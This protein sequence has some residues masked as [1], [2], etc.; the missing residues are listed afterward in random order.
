[1]TKLI[2][3]LFKPILLA[4]F[5]LPRSLQRFSASLLGFLWFDLLRVR[6]KIVLDNLRLAFPEWSEDRRLNVA[7]QS[8]F[9][10]GLNITDVLLL[11]FI[12]RRWVD[13]NFVFEGM[14]NYEA[15][16]K[17]GKG[18]LF[19]SLHL[20]SGDLAVAAMSLKGMPIHCI[21]KEFK[22]QWLNNLWFTARRRHG[23]RF[24]SDRKS[25]FDIL[26]ALR[27]N[28]FVVFVFDQFMGPPLGIR[29]K[30]FGVETGS[31]AGLALIADRAECPVVPVY[32]FH[33]P[34]QKIVLKIDPEIPFARKD[35][36][37]GTIAHMTQVYCDYLETLVRQYPEQWMWLHRRWKEYRH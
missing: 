32:T 21:T 1:M 24:I 12:D 27:K 7:R 19:L 11:P 14:E 36:R 23:T 9:H 18:A 22:S 16:V 17:K 8:M 29:T 13:E 15:V 4:F 2:R 34:D 6:R 25:S 31:T 35:D 26:R 3:L 37:D 28:E 30:F 5:Y 33:R 20:G 10:V